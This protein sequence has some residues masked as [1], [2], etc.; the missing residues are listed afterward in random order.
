MAFQVF[1]KILF[2]SL[3]S[4]TVY[5]VNIYKDGTLPSGYPLTLK[6]AAQPFVTEEDNDEDMFMPIRT[7]SGYLNIVDDGYAE[8]ANGNT[9]SFNWKE[10]VPTIDT[11][12]PV[13]L[14]HSSGG[15]TYIDW[16]GY[17]QSQNF[18]GTLYGNPQE[19]S[20]PIHCVLSSV[21]GTDINYTQK[22]L[23][24]FAYLLKKVL[25]TIDYDSGSTV[26][27]NNIIVQGGSDAQTWLLK[28][29][30]WQNFCDEDSDGN[31]E[32][33]YSM[34]E[35]FEGMCRFWGWTAR[36]CGDTLYL[37]CVDDSAEQTFLELT[38]SE[39]NTM[40]SGT[41]DGTVTG[42]FYTES[43][44]GDIFASINN[45][46][47]IVR[48]PE[49]ATVTSNA[50]AAD[51]EFIMFAP[52]KVV[53]QMSH[54][55]WQ[56]RIV[57]DDK[58]VRYTNNLQ[59]FTTPFMEGTA[60][61]GNASFNIA[62]VQESLEEEG[63]R[64]NVI[65][66]LKT[67]SSSPFASLE[68][69]YHHAFKG[70]IVLRGDIYRLAHKFESTDSATK[71]IGNKTMIMRLGIGTSRA[72]AQW[73]NGRTWGSTL[74]TFEATIGNTDSVFRSRS[75]GSFGNGTTHTYVS[76]IGVNGKAGLIFVDFFGSEDID[77][78][79]GQRSF[80]ISDFKLTVEQ[81]GPGRTFGDDD[82][83]WKN[84]QEYKA[85]NQNRVGEDASES[86][87]FATDK[88]L[89]V[90]FGLVSNPNG[91]MMTGVTYGG[92]GSEIPEQH[93]ADRIVGYWATA[94]RKIECEL[95]LNVVGNIYPS[96]KVTM[97]NS[98]LYPI[99]ISHDWRDDIMRLNLMEV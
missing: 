54:L 49:K 1:Y 79:D 18:G 31:L 95:R 37:I 88:N 66:I 39:L 65:R 52:D 62:N 55:G 38:R 98:T 84:S 51:K 56:T 42:G 4:G 93:L 30:D 47:Y 12:R 71:A 94:K 74:T 91:T 26:S 22:E 58:L 6:G 86:N 75:T 87:M 2:K 90:G 77:P 3:R 20:Y 63:T 92:G 67:A 83:D 7:Q 28:N 99:S 44:S 43:L 53:K 69:V 76:A 16:Q 45:N 82:D 8:D 97:D 34:Y 11:D 78:V 32:A 13:T 23:Q 85:S 68:T 33:K 80:D 57:D 21:A 10:L 60:S 64:H 48:G 89:A 46:D 41:S 24:N 70:C 50:N 15:T 73:W 72:N 19:R 29:I 96:Y 36:T 14:T 27:V 61:S 9:V 59:S 25:D 5:T 17:M 40:A 35:C 81:H